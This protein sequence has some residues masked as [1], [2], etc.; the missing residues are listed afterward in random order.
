MV[1]GELMNMCVCGGG[2]GGAR[3]HQTETVGQYWGMENQH[4]ILKEQ[5][6]LKHHSTSLPGPS[7][8]RGPDRRFSF[9]ALAGKTAYK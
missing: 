2:E 5:L 4:A 9:V 1:A 6:M 3:I 8:S 7:V